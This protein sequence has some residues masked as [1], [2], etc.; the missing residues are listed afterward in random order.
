MYSEIVLTL[1]WEVV[2]ST[3]V[4]VVPIINE[5]WLCDIL[6]CSATYAILPYLKCNFMLSNIGLFYQMFTYCS[7]RNNILS[8]LIE[9][10]EVK[11]KYQYKVRH[12]FKNCSKEFCR[13][14]FPWLQDRDDWYNGLMGMEDALVLERYVNK[15]LLDLHQKTE[16][17][18]HVSLHYLGTRLSQY[19]RHDR[20]FADMFSF[21]KIRSNTN[22]FSFFSWS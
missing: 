20:K 16:S 7:T 5:Y 12:P 22:P 17:D 3:L 8:W 1:G 14:L 11:I 2:D 21:S 6:L 15:L 19:L 4:G 9:I 10:L 18:A 13:S